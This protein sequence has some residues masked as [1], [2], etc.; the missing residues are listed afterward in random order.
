MRFL[1]YDD[2]KKIECETEIKNVDMSTVHTF[3]HT[4]VPDYLTRYLRDPDFSYNFF[5]WDKILKFSFLIGSPTNC[6][7]AF[8][9]SRLDGLLCLAIEE[10]KFK[11]EFIATAPWNYYTVGKMRRIGSGL[12]HF[13]IQNS[14]Y[15]GHQGEFY[16][17]AVWDAE[18]FY[19]K[20]GMK[21][22]GNR[23]PDGLKE[24]FMPKNGAVS[25]SKRFEKYL[26]QA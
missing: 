12:I 17:N 7:G 3:I 20:I 25:F 23:N 8:T 14:N 24:Y 26:I 6:Y 11:I 2:K 22:T 9:N 18:Y 19:E 5:R 4:W 1:S 13:T 16:L 10:E 15:T 21:P